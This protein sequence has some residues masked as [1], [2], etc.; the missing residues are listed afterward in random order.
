[1]RHVKTIFYHGT[2][3]VGKTEALLAS[4]AAEVDKYGSDWR[5]LFVRT[6]YKGLEDAIAKAKKMFIGRWGEEN[7]KWKASKDS[8][9]FEFYNGAVLYFRGINSEDSYNTIHGNQFCW[10]GIDE[11]CTFNN[12]SIIDLIKT[13]LR[14]PLYFN[15]D[16]EL[17]DKK[18]QIPQ[19]LRM[20]ANPDGKL[21]SKIKSQYVN[22]CKEGVV[23]NIEFELPNGEKV[24]QSYMHIFGSFKE[25]YNLPKD[26][27]L[28]FEDMKINNPV[29]YRAY[30]YGDWDAISGGALGDYWKHHK[31]VID[32]FNIPDNWKVYRSY[33]HGT[34]SPFACL[35]W[36]ITD[37][38]GIELEDGSWF[39]PPKGTYIVI[40]EF[41]GAKDIVS[42]DVGLRMPTNEIAQTIKEKEKSMI[43]NGFIKKEVIPGPADKAIAN[44]DEIRVSN[45]KSYYRIFKE[46]G[47]D[48]VLLKKKKGNRE[49]GLQRLIELLMNTDK[50]DPDQPHFYVFRNNKFYLENIPS[51]ETNPKNP[52]EVIGI[53]HD[54]DATNYFITWNFEKP[55]GRM[56]IGGLFS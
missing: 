43:E 11:L 17:V 9:M 22:I 16:G 18:D 52:N 38:S 41:Y 10:I 25:N 23:K 21:K 6:D 51:L 33:D 42:R 14:A 8:F 50:N 27:I 34:S 15:E 19:M 46:N 4:Y 24:S 5:G 20:T 26:Y 30:V 37:G 32:P 54:F 49:F 53:D 36:A 56:K 44:N 39:C 7:V 29:R 31:V 28:Q 48:W 13:C 35:W 40:N 3:G 55:K 47:V 45:E 12:I 1:M 2:R